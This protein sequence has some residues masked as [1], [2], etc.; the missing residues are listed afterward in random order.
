MTRSAAAQRVP[1]GIALAIAAVACLAALDTSS[2]V[3][4]VA[5]PIIMAMWCRFAF[6]AAATAAAMLPTRGRA[7]L[8]TRRPGLQLLRGVLLLACS[9]CAFTSFRFMSVGDV[10][11]IGMAAPIVVTLIAVF[12]FGERLSLARLACVAGGFVGTLVIVRPGGP[13]LGWSL[14]APL[15]MLATNTAFQLVTSRL[16]T[17]DDP[18][19]THF[20]T[21]C[22]GLALTTLP[23]PFF[24]TPALAPA[25]WGV[26]LLLGVFSTLGHFLLILAYQRAPATTVMPFLYVQI[27]FAVFGGWLVFSH[28]P[29]GAS[30]LGIA[31]IAASG[32][33]G[34]WMAAREKRDAVALAAQPLTL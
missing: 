12:A 24:W 34:T 16:A 25:L 13:M 3:A 20:Y 18:A 8:R 28:V 15:G 10:T 23:V 32:A 11:A 14:L 4:S 31:L 19:T 1:Q 6:Q 17:I 33:A 2:K 21:G 9:A 5:V 22:I 26:L 29:D 30:W 7:L 27:A